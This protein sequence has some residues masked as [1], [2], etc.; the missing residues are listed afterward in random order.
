MRYRRLR[1]PRQ[2]QTALHDPPLS[3][4]VD[5]LQ[6]NRQRIADQAMSIFP[7][8]LMPGAI[9]IADLQAQA[10]QE[11]L[12]LAMAYSGRYLN[13]KA[14]ADF[15][16][17][18]PDSVVMSGHQPELYHPGV[19]YKNFVLSELARR[20]NAVAIN[21]VVD[22]DLAGRH[23]IRY[24]DLSSEPFRVGSIPVDRA[25][26]AIPHEQREIVDRDFF[27]SFVSR[28]NQRVPSVDPASSIRVVDRLWP[29]V[30]QATRALRRRSGGTPAP[31]GC[32]I[33]RRR[34]SAS[35]SR[36]WCLRR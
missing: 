24:P 36:P 11:I 25:S 21:L 10:R 8:S 15:K 1:V 6:V 14:L 2:N 5:R 34:R 35:V 17:D 9:P 30:V 7:G 27:E 33:Q 20:S 3:Q 19:W 31:P 13:A 16:I 4:A 22:S 32:G 23:S 12:Q 29:H 28:V 18:I 26:A